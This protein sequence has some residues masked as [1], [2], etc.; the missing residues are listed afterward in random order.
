MAIDTQQLL[1]VYA[2]A[3]LQFEPQSIKTSMVKLH[4]YCFLI[5]FL[6]FIKRLLSRAAYS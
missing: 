4:C 3:E 1:F 6:A 5:S 2:L